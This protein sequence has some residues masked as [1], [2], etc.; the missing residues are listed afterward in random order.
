[1]IGP[2]KQFFDSLAEVI[3]KLTAI[4]IAF[5]PYGVFALMAWV[6]GTYGLDVLL[7]LGAVILAVYAGCIIH[8]VLVYGGAIAFI[9]RLNPIRYFQGIAE[10]QAV[11]FTTTSL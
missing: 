5:A 11:A 10:A 6:A 1:M 4:I 2:I 7:P 3:Y 8:A 9:A